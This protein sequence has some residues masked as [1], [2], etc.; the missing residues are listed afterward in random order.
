MAFEGRQLRQAFEAQAD[1]HDVVALVCVDVSIHTVGDPTDLRRPF[2][3]SL[4]V[5]KAGRQLKVIA[6]RAHRHRDRLRI[7]PG[8]QANLQR[9][10]RR[11]LV[12]PDSV[13]P[14]FHNRDAG[15]YF[16]TDAGY[17][18]GLLQ[19]TVE[20]MRRS[21]E[22]TGVNTCRLSEGLPGQLG[23]NKERVQLNS[24]ILEGSAKTT[25]IS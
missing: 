8:L 2:D 25:S 1:V 20:G 12:I 10:F 5:Q 18:L 9:F 19:R 24:P 23:E 7:A 14:A 16:A 3:D 6:G 21:F 11:Q 4:V 15:T 22:C 13:P 17:H